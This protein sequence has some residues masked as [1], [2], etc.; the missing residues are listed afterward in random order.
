MDGKG[1]GVEGSDGNE[2]CVMDTGEVGSLLQCNIEA[3]RVVFISSCF[4]QW[5]LI[6]A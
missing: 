6:L 5:N 3:G 4:E 2:E 1:H